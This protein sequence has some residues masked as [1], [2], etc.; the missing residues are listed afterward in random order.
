MATG[1]TVAEQL[2]VGKDFTVRNP[3]GSPDIE[4]WQADRLVTVP[5]PQ[6]EDEY[7]VMLSK[8][9]PETG[10]R[11]GAMPLLDEFLSWQK[12]PEE[13]DGPRMNPG[14][15]AHA[16]AI[17]GTAVPA[18]V[19]GP[20]EQPS[21]ESV[22]E[23]RMEHVFAAPDLETPTRRSEI[24]ERSIADAVK[25]LAELRQTNPRLAGLITDRIRGGVS[26]PH[27]MAEALRTDKELR[28][29]VGKEL[30]VEANIRAKAGELPYQLQHDSGKT[31]TIDGYPEGL[32]SR[33]YA[34]LL[35]L[36]M[37]DGTFKRELTG[38]DEPGLRGGQH[39]TAAEQLLAASF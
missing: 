19:E 34:A 24:T 21:A 25:R 18:M 1:P 38:G 36:S 17:A 5:G 32:S 39:R 29:A 9:D 15:R 12:T 10:D 28:L 6:G 30:L 20:T 14:L 7:R 35:A 4:G 37:L 11:I 8:I 2:G 26:D 27:Q 3:D 31:P 23:G 13:L 22:Y 16:Q 33:E